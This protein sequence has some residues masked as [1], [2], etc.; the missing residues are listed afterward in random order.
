M[1]RGC[2]PTRLR[3]FSDRGLL[4]AGADHVT[5][6]CPFW[7]RRPQLSTWPDY[8]DELIRQGPQFLEFSNLADADIAVFPLSCRQLLPGRT[9]SR[10]RSASTN[11]RRRQ[12]SLVCSSDGADTSYQ[13]FPIEDAVSCAGRSIVRAAALV[14]SRCPD[15]TTTSRSTRGV[16]CRFAGRADVRWSL[17]AAL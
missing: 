2:G 11:V 14:S 7:G 15:S 12:A 6:L 9:G 3:V 1:L 5:I 8:A 4:P 10:W 13:P 16:S 17:S